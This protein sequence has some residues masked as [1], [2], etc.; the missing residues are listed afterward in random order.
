[1]AIGQHFAFGCEV[2]ANTLTFPGYISLHLCACTSLPPG[3]MSPTQIASETKKS[4]FQNAE[5]L[6]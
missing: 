4:Y 6:C 5:L 1:M 2:S 3:D